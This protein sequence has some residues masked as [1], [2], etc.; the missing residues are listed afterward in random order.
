MA[1]AG[2]DAPVGRR[3]HIKRKNKETALKVLRR[4]EKYLSLYYRPALARASSNVVAHCGGTA[5]GGGVGGGT[6]LVRALAP[7]RS[8]E[9]LLTGST[10]SKKKSPGSVWNA[11]NKR[12]IQSPSLFYGLPPPNGKVN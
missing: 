11:I 5:A 2:V 4:R 7:V 1:A 8:P 3:F 12:L 9:L 6:R 10:G